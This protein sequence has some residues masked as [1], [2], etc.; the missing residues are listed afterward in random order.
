MGYQL[1]VV[2][3][4][5]V[6]HRF[7]VQS[8]FPAGWPE[9]LH[10]RLRLAFVHFKA[11]RL[12]KVVASLHKDPAFGEALALLADSDITARR[13]ELSAQRTRDDDWF[14]D[15]FNLRW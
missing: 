13:R 7:R 1:L 5:V 14:F 6:R 12:G 15:R 2:P 9:Y 4:T 3:E 11:Q 8:P 10:N